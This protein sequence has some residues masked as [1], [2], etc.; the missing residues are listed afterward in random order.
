MAQM[1]KC[2]E[3][4]MKFILLLVCAFISFVHILVVGHNLPN[5]SFI[6]VAKFSS[7]G[8][9]VANQNYIQGKTILCFLLLLSLLCETISHSLR[10]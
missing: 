4:E 10:T 9:A 6:N 1:L 5:K 2:Y 8:R 3:M 7:L